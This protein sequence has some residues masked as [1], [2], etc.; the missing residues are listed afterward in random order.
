MSCCSPRL[1]IDYNALGSQELVRYGIFSL[2][3]HRFQYG[4]SLNRQ[5][6]KVIPMWHCDTDSL[7]GLCIL[8]KIFSVPF[9]RKIESANQ[10]S[11]Q[12]TVHTISFIL[13]ITTGYAPSWG[14]TTEFLSVSALKP[15]HNPISIFGF[16]ITKWN[17]IE[18]W[19]AY[20]M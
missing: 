20:K 17:K 13:I 10:K 7:A 5:W 6:I 12:G 2:S 18:N 1:S 15:I 19:K 8:W 3:N 9:K 16:Y 11:E 14:R 4:T